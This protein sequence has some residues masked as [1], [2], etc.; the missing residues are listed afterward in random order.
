MKY[1]E[2]IQGDHIIITPPIAKLIDD[3]RLSI[4]SRGFYMKLV[5]YGRGYFHS[6]AEIVECSKESRKTIKRCMDELVKFGYMT[7]EV[8]RR[9]FEYNLSCW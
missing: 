7:Y 4:G 1:Q 9:H 6:I 3:N 5:A 2:P 8:D